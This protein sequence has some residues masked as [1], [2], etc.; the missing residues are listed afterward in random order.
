MEP[1]LEPESEESFE[2]VLCAGD[3]APLL[4]CVLGV[5]RLNSPEAGENDRRGVGC[6]GPSDDA[7]DNQSLDSP[8]RGC[9]TGPNDPKYGS[10]G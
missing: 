5:S 2:P 4:Y 7:R 8:V 3:Q 6:S 1:T 10:V 9:E